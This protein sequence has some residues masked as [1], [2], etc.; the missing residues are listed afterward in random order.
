MPPVDW[1]ALN[2]FA[3]SFVSPSAPNPGAVVRRALLLGDIPLGDQLP[4]S[5]KA[6]GAGVIVF[7]T[8]VARDAAVDGENIPVRQYTVHFERPEETE[9]EGSFE[10]GGY[11][12]LALEKSPLQHWNKTDVLIAMGGVANPT[13]I[14]PVCFLGADFTAVIVTARYVSFS[15]IPVVLRL[16]KD[17]DTFSTADIYPVRRWGEGPDSLDSNP[18]GGATTAPTTAKPRTTGRGARRCTRPRSA[19]GSSPPTT[20]SVALAVPRATPRRTPPWPSPR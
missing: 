12:I 2:R 9:V 11:V 16:K 19:S 1:T 5:A 15:D 13:Q 8:P 6:R 7:N 14:S 20:A 18:G 10:H 3:Y 4:I 17:D